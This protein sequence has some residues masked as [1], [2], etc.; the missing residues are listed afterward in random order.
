MT[1]FLIKLIA[2][3]GVVYLI[4]RDTWRVTLNTSNYEITISFVLFL[5]AL[6]FL[7]WLLIQIKKPFSWWGQFCAWR[8]N[9]KRNQKD[10]FL[11]TLLTAVLSHQSDKA[12]VLVRESEKLYGKGSKE[13][14]LVSALLE[15][16]A[17]VFNKLNQADQTKLAGLYGLIKEAE[18]KGDF[19][20]MNAL[21]QQVPKTQEK[22]LWVQQAKMFLALT[23]SDWKTALDIL[24]Q[25][26]KQLSKSDYKSHKASLLLKLGRL[27]EAYALAPSHPAI[28]LTYAKTLPVRKAK[29]V[30]EKAWRVAPN[31]QIYLAYKQ[32]IKPLPENKRLK[33][34]LNLTRATRDQ[35]YSLLARADM[36]TDLHNWARAKENLE[37]YLQSYP[38]TRQVANMMANL[39]RTAWRHE[40]IAND[41]DRKA[42]ESEDD[43]LWLCRN[44]GHT[45]GEWQILC[46]HC[47]A[48]DTLY[49][50]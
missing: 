4:A 16:Q 15:P 1:K 42:I 48:F 49:N 45:V 46:P 9:K 50:K 22:T 44:C 28:V 14:L 18:A 24:E 23:H 17:D 38:L 34:V 29:A 35:R 39:E 36:D 26:K 43:S 19:E 2:L 37:I 21:L 30:L 25:N 13:V 41:W 40:D 6:I 10:S 5:V 8:Q 20:E 7:W 47:N 27:K 11:P 3:A 12:N 33:S 32:V 31:W